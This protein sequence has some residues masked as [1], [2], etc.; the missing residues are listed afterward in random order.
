MATS[1]I[2][3][4]PFH[5][6]AIALLH[7]LEEEALG[8]GYRFMSR[9]RTELED[10]SNRFYKPGEALFLAW[11]DDAVVGVCGLN[12][13][14]YLGDPRIG[15]VRHLYVCK[16]ARRFGV[17]RALVEAVIEA[18]RGAFDTLTLRTENP[19]ASRLYRSLGFSEEPRF[20]E[21]THWLAF[22]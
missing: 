2:V 20:N 5:A 14:P 7:P 6:S 9:L 22:N 19:D 16:G 21:A 8:D 18:A 11:Q 4:E 1:K 10:G 15:R 13:D 12:Q 3:I 17:G